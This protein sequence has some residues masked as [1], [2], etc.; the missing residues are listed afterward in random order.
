MGSYFFAENQHEY[1]GAICGQTRCI[2]QVYPLAAV[3][4]ESSRFLE[5]LGILAK[6]ISSVRRRK[7]WSLLEESCKSWIREIGSWNMRI[8]IVVELGGD[9]CYESLLAISKTLNKLKTVLK[10]FEIK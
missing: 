9:I 4:C 3:P 1:S 8:E 6:K 2:E 7:R 5:S 10:N